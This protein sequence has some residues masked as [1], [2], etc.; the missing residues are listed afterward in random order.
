MINYYPVIDYKNLFICLTPNDIDI[1]FFNKSSLSNSKKWN[2]PYGVLSVNNDAGKILKFCDGKH[3]IFDILSKYNELYDEKLSLNVLNEFLFSMKKNEVIIFCEEKTDNFNV[4]VF[5]G[6][7]NNF[8]PRHFSIELTNNCNLFCKH[9]YNNSSNNNTDY[10]NKDILLSF[11][12]DFR[13]N[14]GIVVE[15][16]GGEPLLHPDFFEIFE[17]C[18]NNF[19]SVAILSNGYFLNEEILEKMIDFQEKIIFNVSLDSVDEKYHNKFRGSKDAYKKTINAI[20]LL[21]KYNFKHRVAMSVTKE[22]FFHVED[23]IIFLK[24]IGVPLFGYS[25]V[26]NFG[27]GDNN[28]S[29]FNDNEEYLKFAEYEEK[30]FNKYSD[31]ISVL[32]DEQKETLEFNNCG[33]IHRTATISANGDIRPCVMFDND[34]SIGNIYN[35]SLKNIFSKEIVKQYSELSVPSERICGDCEDLPYCKNCVLRGLKKGIVRKYCKWME[36]NGLTQDKLRLI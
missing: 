19:L 7:L 12:K 4:N 31:F 29:L 22:N 18:A 24:K 14:G 36:T 25:P 30:I 2:K 8:S 10:L 20:K 32:N 17:Y 9:C 5:R 15:L 13:D 21:V 11:L 33:L 1:Y 26:L 35:E 28:E 16:T 23:T 3:S 34:F 27:R 6:N